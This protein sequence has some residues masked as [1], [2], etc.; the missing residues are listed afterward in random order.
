MSTTIRPDGIAIVQAAGRTFDF[1]ALKELKAQ[2]RDGR[3]VEALALWLA[4]DCTD[5]MLVELC[6]AV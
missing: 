3:S 2:L 1:G 4:T 6:E 5:P